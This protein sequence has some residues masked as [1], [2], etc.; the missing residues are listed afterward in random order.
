MPQ[1]C[2][3]GSFRLYF[4][5]ANRD[6]CIVPHNVDSISSIRQSLYFPF[7]LTNRLVPNIP[8]WRDSLIILAFLNFGNNAR[9]VQETVCW[10]P[11]YPFL[12]FQ[13]GNREMYVSFSALQSSATHFG[14]L[15]SASITCGQWPW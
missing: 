4:S 6:W 3:N 9:L 14:K 8:C 7:Y 12:L 10:P 15:C 1:S 5:L 13:A 2:M 11:A